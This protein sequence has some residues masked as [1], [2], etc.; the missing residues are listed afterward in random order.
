[1]KKTTENLTR[2]AL[3][4]WFDGNFK[5][6]RFR[7]GP[8]LTTFAAFIVTTIVIVH[9]SNSGG[10][11]AEDIRDFEAGKVA[12]QDV[13]AGESVAYVDEEATRLRAEAKGRLVPAVFRVSA[14]ANSEMRSAWQRFSAF[15]NDLIAEGRSVDAM[16]LAV[17]SE[18]PAK[19]SDS[20][21]D[22]YFTDPGRERFGE[23]GSIALE[24]LID[25]GVFLLPAEIREAYNPDTVEMLSSAGE[26]TEQE[27]VPYDTIV[28][29]DKAGDAINHYIAG[30][31]FPSSFALIA[32]ELL[33]PFITENTFFSV[34]DTR[35][36]SAEARMR[37]E[38]VV[39]QIEEG[40]RII[41]KGFIITSEDMDALRALKMAS[42][43]TDVRGI[44]G[45]ILILILLY[46][47]FIFIG[48]ERVIGRALSNRE[49]YLLAALISMYLIGA[50][51]V[52]D[53]N[54]SSGSI[55]VSIVLPTALV[56]MLPSILIGHRLALVLA[57]A[58]PLGA[59]L[60][61]SF[62]TSAYIF[63]LV[64]AVSASH[65]LKGAKKRM[66]LIKAGVF[67]AAANCAG[68]ITILLFRRSGPGVYPPALFWGAFNGIASGMLVLGI[69][70][71]LEHVLN[72]ATAFRLIELSDLNAPVLRRLFTAAPGT[73]SHS[74]MVANLAEAAC[75]DIGANPLLAR[76]GAYYHDIGKMENPDYFVE[77][78][79][80]YNKHDDIAPRLSATVI[81][82]HVK[83]GV[84]KARA[85]GLPR[86]VIAIIA[87][88]HGNSVITW[89]FN[90]ALKQEASDFQQKSAVNMEDFTYPGDPPHSRESAVVMLADVSEAAVRTL[91]KPTA[92]KIEKFIQEL[93]NAKVEH[94]QLAQSELTFRDLETIKNA[95]VR[96]LA[97]YYHS[98]IEYPKMGKDGPAEPA[99]SK[100]GSAGGGGSRG[101]HE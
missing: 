87:E 2:E 92:A 76:V 100:S 69:L 74:I 6:P 36:R 43:E 75:Q 38:P 59:Y 99:V 73:Y 66:D 56:V 12:E 9:Y 80:V 37:I 98:R 79:T 49:I 93:F 58:L 25:R 30:G 62:D 26:R 20:A 67:S 32:S 70:P 18:Y 97:G 83:L 86:E 35:Q 47:L 1:M 101:V 5:I 81:R 39:R 3:K 31:S 60:S 91:S 96:V 4:A 10:G 50:V 33:Y 46:A 51:F 13:V 84:E 71:L 8:A 78:Q 29:K 95:F 88:H 53:L 85:L 94:G 7:T 11:L 68:V 22:V 77:N 40:K 61:G 16:K 23:Y 17:H 48:S 57:M 27:L 44:A 45:Q 15:T 28:T 64:S 52:R 19:F 24:N 54:F 55:P 41:R 63:A 42:T 21:L 14:A 34:E 72:A 82:S 89:F 65:A 90:K